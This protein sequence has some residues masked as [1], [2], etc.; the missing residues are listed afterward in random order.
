MRLVTGRSTTV[1]FMLEGRAAGRGELKLTITGGKG[2]SDAPIH[3][4]PVKAALLHEAASVSGQTQ[5]AVAQGLAPLGALH[6]SYGGL[7]LSLSSTALTGVEYGIEQ[8]IAYPYGCLEQ[9]SS[10]LLAMIGRRPGAALPHG[11]AQ[12][13]TQADRDRA[14]R[15][16]G[17]AAQRWGL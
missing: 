1:R 4:L 3:R 14:H 8:L 10:R 5:A 6:P 16:D 13:A 12:R 9:L 7:E 17:D 11:S 2:V 15:G